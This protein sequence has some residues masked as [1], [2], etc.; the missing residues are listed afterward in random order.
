MAA[1]GAIGYGVLVSFTRPFTLP[2]DVATAVP[3]VAAAGLTFGSLRQRQPAP[4]AAGPIAA[5]TGPRTTG[6][7]TTSTDTTG[8]DTTGPKTTS[9]ARPWRHGWLP[10]AALVA[11]FVGW[12]LATYFA[13]PR[14]AHPTLSVVIDLTDSIRVGKTLLVSAWLAL[15]WY[16]VRR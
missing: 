2:A 4:D 8:T 15:G 10:W 11:A 9:T 1:A 14:T 16:L 13:S 3:I 12:E 7:K 5:T 6:P